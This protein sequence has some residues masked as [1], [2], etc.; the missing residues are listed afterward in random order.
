MSS[1]TFRA[2]ALALALT[3]LPGC[4]LL[5]PAETL[6]SIAPEAPVVQELALAQQPTPTPTPTPEPV[7]HVL[8]FVGDCTLASSQYA[9]GT[10]SAF[11]AVMNGDYGYPYKGD[12]RRPIDG[13]R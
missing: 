9:Q 7:E 3:L 8:T 10:A 12:D 5:A 13:R 1:K 4:G 11:P 6:P 2:A